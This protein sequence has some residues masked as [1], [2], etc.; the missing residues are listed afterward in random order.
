M[1]KFKDNA[2]YYSL[3]FTLS[4]DYNK[5]TVFIA[6]ARPYKYS[7]L[8]LNLLKN[9]NALMEYEPEKYPQEKREEP[10]R[11]NGEADITVQN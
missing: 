5:D 1:K 3:S 11:F 9:E 8:I 4:F 10:A 7:S 6:Y 2:Y